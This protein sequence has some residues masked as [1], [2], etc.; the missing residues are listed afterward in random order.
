MTFRSTEYKELY[1]NPTSTKEGFSVAS[2]YVS[3]DL[4]EPLTPC[5]QRSS[6]QFNKYQPHN[7]TV[8]AVMRSKMKTVCLPSNC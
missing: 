1:L 2:D 7:E 6:R 5:Q 8:S 4:S 3:V